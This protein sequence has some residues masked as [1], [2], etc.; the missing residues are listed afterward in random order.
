[1]NVESLVAA[2]D[3]A[4]KE[5]LSRMPSTRTVAT[6][7]ENGGSN[8]P[9]KQHRSSISVHKLRKA[10]SMYASS[11]TAADGD[12]VHGYGDRHARVSSIDDISFA[13]P[14]YPP[15]LPPP[16]EEENTITSITE[17]D[18]EDTVDITTT[19]HPA[20]LTRVNLEAV[21][22]RP[23]ELANQPRA[24]TT[25][26][27]RHRASMM[28]TP[29][30]K[31]RNATPSAT[32]PPES[33]GHCTPTYANVV[34]VPGLVAVPTP[35]HDRKRVGS[36]V[37][38]T[39]SI[40]AKI[41][42]VFRR[43]SNPLVELPVQ[44]VNASR[45]YFSQGSTFGSKNKENMS[46]SKGK[47][48]VAPH[49]FLQP[50]I[51]AARE[52]SPSHSMMTDGT[53]SRVTSWADSTIAGTILEVDEEHHASHHEGQHSSTQK[54][55]KFASL[56]LLKRMRRTSKIEMRSSP[57]P[58]H[59][60]EGNTT[61]RAKSRASSIPSRKTSGAREMLPSQIRKATI[62]HKS[63]IRAIPVDLSSDS[64]DV[65]SSELSETSGSVSPELRIP[66]PDDQATFRGR[67]YTRKP[68]PLAVAA[69]PPS[70]DQIA[71]RVRKSEERWQE[72]L[73]GGRS[74]FFPRSPNRASP[75]RHSRQTSNAEAG[76][77]SD[78][79]FS[80]DGDTPRR[81]TGIMSPSIYSQ[82]GI[83]PNL[84][85]MAKLSALPHTPMPQPGTAVV[86]DSHHVT[87]YSVGSPK[88]PEHD[89]P[90]KSSREWR[91]WIETEVGELETSAAEDLQLKVEFTPRNPNSGHHKEAAQIMD[92][93]S[94][95][96]FIGPA[97][98][99]EAETSTPIVHRKPVPAMAWHPTQPA[100]VVQHV[101]DLESESGNAQIPA[102]HDDRYDQE[103]HT[104]NV[105]R[106]STQMSSNSRDRKMSYRYPPDDRPSSRLQN[107]DETTSIENRPSGRM[108]DRFPFIP[109]SRPQ[110]R[111]SGHSSTPAQSL[112]NRSSRPTM[113]QKIQSASAAEKNKENTAPSPAVSMRTSTIPTRPRLGLRRPMSSAALVSGA[114]RSTSALAHYTTNQT[115]LYQHE[116]PSASLPPTPQP[117]P[118]LLPR[119]VQSYSS[120]RRPATAT[121]V[122]TQAGFVAR[123]VAVRKMK[124]ISMP[125]LETDPRLASI[126]QGP[127]R[128]APS[129]TANANASP[130]PLAIRRP[131]SS[132]SNKENSSPLKQRSLPTTPKGTGME[133]DG[134]GMARA[135]VMPTSGQRLAEQFLNARRFREEMRVMSPGE[136]S[137]VSVIERTEL[138]TGES[139]PAFL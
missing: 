89:E 27:L 28:L 50:S 13:T 29:F 119:P 5:A 97:T 122:R 14:A 22:D 26:S 102:D 112:H 62:S 32:A 2:R 76:R 92:D 37:K 91:S 46:G 60:S 79:V 70:P 94:S 109:S 44:Q 48:A 124:H 42:S 15:P 104:A 65:P 35:K 88:K 99:G 105:A 33:S 38:K 83:S 52:S 17:L 34:R 125:S 64:I 55:E 51:P 73:D 3:F 18:I 4:A 39:G 16:L 81:P 11:S 131:T 23:F 96:E 8:G 67:D 61:L 36:E 78:D 133:N 115:H 69:V 68:S 40:K 103:E 58:D 111:A 82:D 113:V 90:R 56:S 121:A 45:Q 93:D 95:D 10:K 41:R 86:L 136:G 49:T 77:D 66:G 47:T 134:M 59:I 114:G 98:G 129:T 110:S 127:Y 84:D 7:Q 54:T 106:P 31:R 80:D 101:V 120:P 53:R 117:Q 100:K 72:P 75:E 20:P 24:M 118:S 132:Y 108:N 71:A 21:P 57:I 30:K 25:Q 123:D 107:I 43:T 126:L 139:S 85:A 19:V 12:T 9:F 137:P 74:L 116:S 63:S 1:M 135:S 87:R 6:V 128:E 130:R 138:S